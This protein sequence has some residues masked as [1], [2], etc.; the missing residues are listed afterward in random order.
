MKDFTETIFEFVLKELKKCQE[1]KNPLLH[2]EEDMKQMGR[3]S[4]VFEL[5]CELGLESE[6]YN[7]KKQVIE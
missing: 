3:F 2:N 4:G 7:W 6:Y 1:I 5:L